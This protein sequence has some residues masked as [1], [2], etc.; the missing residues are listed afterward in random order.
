MIC[1]T[2]S[3]RPSRAHSLTQTF[4]TMPPTRWITVSQRESSQM[5]LYA[6]HLVISTHLPLR[7]RLY[8]EKAEDFHKGGQNIFLNDWSNRCCSTQRTAIQIVTPGS[9]KAK[10]LTTIKH[11]VDLILCFTPLL[12]ETDQMMLAFNEAMVIR[13]HNPIPCAQKPLTQ[14]PRLSCR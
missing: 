4:I 9:S 7:W 2:N 10:H 1:V 14:A 11:T 5:S 8:W 13:P 3:L 12:R 6:S